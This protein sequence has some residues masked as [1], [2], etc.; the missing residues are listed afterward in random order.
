MRP[1]V[2]RIE[3]DVNDIKAGDCEF[4]VDI[5]L[6]SGDSLIVKAIAVG[7]I[8]IFKDD[9]FEVTMRFSENYPVKTQNYSSS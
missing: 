3:H 1:P 9:T 5:E 6:L 4:I 2:K 7:P 8:S